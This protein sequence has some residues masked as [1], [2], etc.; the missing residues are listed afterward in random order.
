[1]NKALND[2]CELALK[3]IL[4]GEHLILMTDALISEDNPDQKVQSKRKTYEPVALCSKITFTTQFKMAIYPEEN[5]AIYMAFPDF[6]NIVWDTTT[7]TIVL[8]DSK[9]ITRLFQTKANP[10][11]VWNACDNVLQINFKT[12]HIAWSVNT[13]AQFLIRIELKVTEKRRPKFREDIQTIPIELTKSFSDVADEGQYFSQ[14][15]IENESEEQTL[16]RNKTIVASCKIMS[17]NWATIPN[18]AKYQGVF[19]A[20]RKHY[21]VLQD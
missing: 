13:A 21:V 16:K 2:A 1:M 5:L 3:Q 8:T 17:C 14:A 4:T 15:D 11:S 19:K 18:K 9:S 10:S 7:A 6:D 12:A 20:R